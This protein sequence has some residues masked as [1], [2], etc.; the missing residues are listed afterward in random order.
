[1]MRINGLRITIACMAVGVAFLVVGGPVAAQPGPRGWGPGMMMGPGMMGPGGM[2]G[3]GMCSPRGAG[4]AEWRLTRIEERVQPTE[5]QRTKLNELRDASAKA[6]SI[7]A[8]ACPSE[9]PQSSAS[10]LE[11]MEKRLQAMLEAIK[12]VR[13]AFAAFYDSLSKEQQTRFD[14]VGPRGWG[15]RGWRSQQRD[16]Q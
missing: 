8:A 2:W 4:L 12:M 14:A 13:P 10:R 5:A 9:V 6:A 16:S 3:G 15:W 7:I 11:L 1:M